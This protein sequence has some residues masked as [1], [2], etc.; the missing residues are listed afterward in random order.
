MIVPLQ[1]AVI[2]GTVRAESDFAYQSF[3]LQVAE[4]IVD[5]CER[6]AW[7]QLSRTLKDLIRGRMLVR[8]AD[9]PKD[10]LALF[11]KS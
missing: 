6:D 3:D 4:R 11:R 2:S 8:F 5:G 7:Q 9:Y 10:S 1:R